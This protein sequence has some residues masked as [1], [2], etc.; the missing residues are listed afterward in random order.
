MSEEKKQYTPKQTM[1]L[2]FELAIGHQMKA[3]DAAGV[4]CAMLVA[5]ALMA[6]DGVLP[7][8]FYDPQ[9]GW[10]F[11]EI[12]DPTEE[13]DDDLDE[14]EPWDEDEPVAVEAVP[15]VEPDL[16]PEPAEPPAS[17]GETEL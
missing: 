15:A 6:S 8:M 13:D 17:G 4:L 12:I 7:L 11:A 1:Q 2:V 5:Q 10:L 3:Q 9:A 16:V 14:G